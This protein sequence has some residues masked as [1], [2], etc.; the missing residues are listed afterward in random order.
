[1]RHVSRTHRVD[2]DWLYDRINLDMMNQIKYVKTTALGKHTHQSFFFRDRWTQ[3]TLLANINHI[4][5]KLF[6]S[7][8]WE[9][10]V[11]HREY[12]PE[13]K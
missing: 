13:S 2:L 4:H 12:I 9:Y 8:L 11:S 1:M 3:L 6:V 10:K 7:L 5:L